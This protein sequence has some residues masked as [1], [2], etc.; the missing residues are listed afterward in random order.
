MALRRSIFYSISIDGLIDTMFTG[1][2]Q[3]TGRVAARSGSMLRITARL[4]ARAGD[5][6]AVNG[7]CLTVTPP[8]RRGTL[9]F[10]V[11]AETWER[12]S[13]GLLRPG[14]LVNLEPALR[15]GDALGGHIVSGHV[16]ADAK[17][18]ALESQ[19]GGFA[20]LRVELPKALKGLVAVKGSVAVDGISLT[21]TKVAPGWFEAAL[22][23]HTLKNTNLKGARAGRRVN[24]EADLI[25]RYVRAALER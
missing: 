20:R 19:P 3:R 25:A 17:V 14:D 9:S 15:A 2:I 21:V 1:I 24:L 13:L 6:V 11:S 4:S 12:T 16:D 10:D 5:S 7:T 22:V 18:L 23:P 8:V